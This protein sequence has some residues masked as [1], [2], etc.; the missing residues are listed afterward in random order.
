MIAAD[1]ARSPVGVRIISSRNPIMPLRFRRRTTGPVKDAVCRPAAKR[2]LNAIAKLDHYADCALYNQGMLGNLGRGDIKKLEHIAGASYAIEATDLAY[3]TG[4]VFT[5]IFA[6]QDGSFKTVA[7]VRDGKDQVTGF[8]IR[9]DLIGM[10]GIYSGKHT[11]NA[12]ALENSIVCKVPFNALELLGKESRR[13]QRH[14]HRILAIEMSRQA[15]LIMLLGSMS[16]EERV[17]RFL[18]NTSYALDLRGVT[19]G[20]FRLRM[21][22]GDISSYLGM[23]LETV[24]RTLSKLQ[25]EA[26]IEVNGKRI[27]ILNMERLRAV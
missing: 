19:A 6:I 15:D 3:R 24:S 8:H 2:A 4:E 11:C 20:Q 22:R 12:I 18:V 5:H 21:T 9:G 13:L 16:A 27:K 17:A 25:Q 7:A 23:A 14:V 10:D 26:L 1:K